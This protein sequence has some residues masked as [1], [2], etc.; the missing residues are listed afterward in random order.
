MPKK[1]DKTF[2]SSRNVTQDRI[3]QHVAR[4]Y[5]PERLPQRTSEPPP[6]ASKRTRKSKPA[7]EPELAFTQDAEL[8]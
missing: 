7:D 8:D 3:D 1:T 5:G 2:G 6:P 4:E